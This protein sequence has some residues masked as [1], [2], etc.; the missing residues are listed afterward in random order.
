MPASASGSNYSARILA[1]PPDSI[2]ISNAYALTDM[3]FTFNGTTVTPTTTAVM[4]GIDGLD[5]SAVDLNAESFWTGLGFDTTKV[6]DCTDLDVAAA[7]VSA[8]KYPRLR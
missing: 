6:W 3:V 7:S 8:R 5:T 2:N 4:T 1:R